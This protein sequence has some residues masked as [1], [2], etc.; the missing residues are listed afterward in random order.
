MRATCWVWGISPQ[1]PFYH[2]KGSGSRLASSKGRRDCKQ[3]VSMIVSFQHEH[4]DVT[5]SSVGV[6]MRMISFVS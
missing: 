2:S 3:M 4:F 6:G 5:Y 1:P